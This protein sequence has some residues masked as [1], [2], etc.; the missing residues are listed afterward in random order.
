[1]PG[2][3]ANLLRSSRSQR[4]LFAL[5]APLGKHRLAKTAKRSFKSH[6]GGAPKNSIACLG[7]GPHSLSGARKR[8]RAEK[9]T[10]CTRTT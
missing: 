2:G 9:R 1:M 6:S 10:P 7:S 5:S 4:G 8:N 3:L